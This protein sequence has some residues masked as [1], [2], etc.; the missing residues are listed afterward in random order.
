MMPL[1]LAEAGKTVMIRHIGGQQEER[2]HFQEL[3]FLVGAELQVVTAQGGDV[4]VEVRGVRFALTREA[5]HL[6]LV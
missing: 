3:G 4:I 1:D 5:A 2:D 6:I